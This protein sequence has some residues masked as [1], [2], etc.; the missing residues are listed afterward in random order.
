VR[1]PLQSLYLLSHESWFALRAHQA[2][3][4]VIKAGLH[5]S[6]RRPFIRTSTS[7]PVYGGLFFWCARQGALTW[8][9]KSSTYSARGTVTVKA[10]N[11]EDGLSPPADGKDAKAAGPDP[12]T[13]L[14]TWWVTSDERK[15]VSFRERQGRGGGRSFRRLRAGPRATLSNAT[16]PPSLRTLCRS[17]W[18]RFGL[19]LLHCR[20]LCRK[21][22][23]QGDSQGGFTAQEITPAQLDFGLSLAI[24]SQPN[25]VGVDSNLTS[26]EL[27]S[28]HAR[29]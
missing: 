24:A 21:R 19:R 28:S 12:S 26:F 7:P 29:R 13:S 16:R 4:R 18:R 9:W 2:P 1:G 11:V 3:P 22:S 8:R 25:A 6:Q 15:R 20:P 17:T 23:V 5:R 14:C 27:M 10:P